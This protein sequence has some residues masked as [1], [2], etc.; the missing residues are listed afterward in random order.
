M[1]KISRVRVVVS[2]EPHL[3]EY[4]LST[5]KER[6][7]Q[8]PRHMDDVE[9]LQKVGVIP[10]GIGAYFIYKNDKDRYMYS[11]RKG[12]SDGGWFVPYGRTGP[13]PGS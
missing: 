10:K 9:G 8:E 12:F 1:S 11:W 4:T 13:L 3:P 7:M 5:G 2:R 6:W